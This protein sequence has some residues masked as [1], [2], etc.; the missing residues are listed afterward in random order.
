M[1]T[2][3]T[4]SDARPLKISLSLA[5]GLLPHS[6]V[7]HLRIAPAPQRTADQMQ[8]TAASSGLR[9][10]ISDLPGLRDMYTAFEV[11]AHIHIHAAACNNKISLSDR[12]GM[13]PGRHVRTV[14]SSSSPALALGETGYLSPIL[15]HT[16][17]ALVACDDAISDN[18]PGAGPP[19]FAFTVHSSQQ[20]P[21]SVQ[22]VTPAVTGIG[23][24]ATAMGLA[25]RPALID[26]NIDAD[27]D[28][29]VDV[30]E[31]DTR[32]ANVI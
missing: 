16:S 22:S 8:Q 20:A 12:R 29:D 4:A 31:H 21:A 5:A 27:T 9:I 3:D 2:E 7:P 15:D 6:A 10:Q 28:I 30:H 18:G 14:R 11:C 25:A 17:M 24:A 19:F 32:H 23:I 13:P 1:D 26:S